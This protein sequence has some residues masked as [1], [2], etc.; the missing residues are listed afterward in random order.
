MSEEDLSENPASS[1]SCCVTLS[2]SFNL[3]EPEFPHLPIAWWGWTSW[4]LRSFLTPDSWTQ[5]WAKSK[6][7]KKKRL[8]C[9]LKDLHSF[10]LYLVPLDSLLISPSFSG[11]QWTSDGAQPWGAAGEDCMACHLPPLTPI[12]SPASQTSQV[13]FPASPASLSPLDLDVGPQGRLVGWFS[14]ISQLCS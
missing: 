12:L 6:D 3:S 4:P 2:W 10:P 13:S 8:S 11:S 9:F 1:I 14:N 5:V 7:K